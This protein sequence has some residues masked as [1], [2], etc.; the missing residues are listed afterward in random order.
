M[1]LLIL[2]SLSLFVSKTMFSQNDSTNVM[3]TDS[4]IENLVAMAYENARVKSMENNA[5]QSEYEY[6]RTKT[7][8]L[9]NVIIAGNLNEFSLTQ[10]NANNTDPLRQSTQFP[11]YNVG[12]VLPLGIVVNN[13]RQTKAS[14]YSY[15]S[16]LDQVEVEK[17][18]I[19]REVQINYENFNYTRQLLM[20]QDEIM[21]DGELLKKV[22]E[23]KFKNEEIS[24]ETYLASNKA[25]NAEKVKRLGL[26]HE[27]EIASAQLE[28]LIGMKIDDALRQ[29][30]V[31]TT[32]KK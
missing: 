22:Q 20:L 19:R 7:A 14:Y 9:N 31:R 16:K 2:I 11:R 10:S 12:V 8:W 15:Q 5:I 1:K 17:Q 18:N 21:Q 13:R 32:N 26:Y 28:A 27:L 3:S 6:K 29:M 4:V 25:Y 23:E 30:S 24:I